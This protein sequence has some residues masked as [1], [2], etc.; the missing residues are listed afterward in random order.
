MAAC[1][2]R[3]IVEYD[4]AFTNE[5]AVHTNGHMAIVIARERSADV[6]THKDESNGSCGQRGD[7]LGANGI[8]SYPGHHGCGPRPN[9]AEERIERN[10]VQFNG[11]EHQRQHHPGH[12]NH[13]VHR[14]GDPCVVDDVLMT[15]A[16]L[17]CGERGVGTTASL[18]M[19][20]YSD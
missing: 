19:P 6:R 15:T 4:H 11:E 9:G 8:G 13:V 20:T 1:S 14:G 7:A 16:L 5:T 18:L 2:T 17:C 10:V 12:G 3:H